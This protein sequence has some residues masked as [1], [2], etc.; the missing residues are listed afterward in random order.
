MIKRK[1]EEDIY[2]RGPGR[3]PQKKE[4]KSF[5]ESIIWQTK[6]I[7]KEIHSNNLRQLS[8]PNRAPEESAPC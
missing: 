1:K 5:K 2:K 4:R 3:N 7:P 6:S 8:Q